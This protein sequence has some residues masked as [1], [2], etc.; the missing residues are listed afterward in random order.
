MNW[1]AVGPRNYSGKNIYKFYISIIVLFLYELVELRG[2]LAPSSTDPAIRPITPKIRYINTKDFVRTKNTCNIQLLHEYHHAVK[3]FL[4]LYFYQFS[5]IPY[6]VVWI[7]RPKARD[8][9]YI[10]LKPTSKRILPHSEQVCIMKVE[11]TSTYYYVTIIFT[12][13]HS[14]VTVSLID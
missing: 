12:Q 3:T 14:L 9:G 6:D 13:Q 1:T 10:I 11:T 2:T 5:K 4:K 8:L 7:F